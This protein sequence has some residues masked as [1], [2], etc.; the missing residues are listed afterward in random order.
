LDIMRKRQAEA[1]RKTMARNAQSSLREYRSG[2]LKKTS[3]S[4]LIDR[5]EEL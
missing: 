2:K 1:R 3:A 5:L 4:E